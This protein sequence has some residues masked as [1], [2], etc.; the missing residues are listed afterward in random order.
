MEDDTVASIGTILEMSDRKLNTIA[1]H[2]H[3]DP[4]KYVLNVWVDQTNPPVSQRGIAS[5]VELS[6]KPDNAQQIKQKYCKYWYSW[7]SK[8]V[9]NC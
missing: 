3:D 6:G 4:Q 1:E 5:T 7:C 9:L 2:E 8:I